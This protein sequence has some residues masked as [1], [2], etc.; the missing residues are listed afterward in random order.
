LLALSQQI[1]TL[2]SN[3]NINGQKNG[4]G[5]FIV[6]DL[7]KAETGVR[8]DLDQLLARVQYL[9]GAAAKAISQRYFDHAQGPQLLVKNAE[10]Q[11][12][13]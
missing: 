1:E 9:I 7:A 11:D 4:L 12:H 13:L 5:F 6:K 10:W 8:Q 3:E 2:L